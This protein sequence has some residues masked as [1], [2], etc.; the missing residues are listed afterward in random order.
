MF[1]NVNFQ[2][3]HDVN[4]KRNSSALTDLP[5]KGISE[6]ILESK[7][8]NNSEEI[9]TKDVEIS[10]L[11]NKDY[12]KILKSKFPLEGS[13]RPLGVLR[14]SDNNENSPR[15]LIHTRDFKEKSSEG[16]AQ[17]END[18]IIS[19]RSNLDFIT[20]NR[21][22]SNRTDTMSNVKK[23]GIGIAENGF[24][25]ARKNKSPRE[26]DENSF[27]KPLGVHSE[28]LRNG[29]KISSAGKNVGNLRRKALTETTN[30]QPS[31]VLGITGKWRCPQKRKPNLGPPMKQLRL[32]RWVHR[33]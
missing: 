24:V 8:A 2:R 10:S 27:T 4:R 21:S 26:N 17:A 19:P 28:S 18:G 13:N 33:V 7:R 23:D 3:N 1:Y 14:S 32:E 20:R 11:C 9:S 12:A 6:Q 16:K 5:L 25:S 30:T 15:K 22:S 29:V 31:D